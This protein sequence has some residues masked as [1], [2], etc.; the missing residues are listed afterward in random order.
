MEHFDILDE[1]GN[2]TGEVKTRDEAHAKGLWHK[3]VHA[4]ILNDQNQLLIQKRAASKKTNPNKWT[5][6]MAGHIK[7][8]DDSITTCIKEM[9][10]ELGL[11]LIESDFELLFNIT[12]NADLHNKKYL[13]NEHQGVYL[14]RQTIDISKLKLQK[15]EVADIRFISINDLKQKV[16]EKDPDFVIHAKKYKKLFEHLEN[17]K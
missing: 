7:C 3:T 12:Q 14:I 13:N 2:K 1:K 16:R 15:E 4:W 8:G 17:K 5:V 6:S 9:R 10:E 11:K